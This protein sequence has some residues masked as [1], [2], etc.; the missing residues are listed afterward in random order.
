MDGWQALLY[1]DQPCGRS[2]ARSSDLPAKYGTH[3]GEIGAVVD[4]LTAKAKAVLPQ[5]DG[6]HSAFKYFMMLAIQAMTVFAGK[7]GVP[8]LL[9]ALVFDRMD[10]V[11]TSAGADVFVEDLSKSLVHVQADCRALR[12]DLA[13]LRDDLL[14]TRAE[15][16]FT[17][18]ELDHVRSELDHVRTE[19]DHMQ[20]ELYCLQQAKAKDLGDSARGSLDG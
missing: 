16:D 6:D 13:G 12:G 10:A 18:G 17:R 15:L 2:L 3:A 11:A 19:R 5:A 8:C 4:R 1:G 20:S 9:Y 14:F 7:D